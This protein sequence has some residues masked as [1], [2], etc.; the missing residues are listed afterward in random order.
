MAK[1]RRTQTK[2]RTRTLKQY[3][4]RGRGKG[5]T[6]GMISGFLAGAAGT[7]LGKWAKLG[8]WAQPAAD[9]GIGYFMKN[10]TLETIGGRSVGA[11]LASGIAGGTT[12]NGTTGYTALS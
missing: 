9:L 1:R 6:G 10:E 7:L 11:M 2:T 3:V 12:T 5:R 4:S 8:T